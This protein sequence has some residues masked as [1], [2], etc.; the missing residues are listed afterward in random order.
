MAYLNCSLKFSV[1]KKEEENHSGWK[2]W[3]EIVK[4]LNDYDYVL[5]TVYD[6]HIMIS[7]SAKQKPW[8]SLK[9]ANNRVT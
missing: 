2:E 6:W 1:K 9:I 7:R 4:D 3:G 8:M 5:I